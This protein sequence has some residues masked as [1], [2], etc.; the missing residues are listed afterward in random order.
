MRKRLLGDGHLLVA[1]SLINL[2]DMLVYEDK[3]AEAEP[4]F[5][6]A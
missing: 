6:E 1:M 4:L 3:F 5:R 2:A